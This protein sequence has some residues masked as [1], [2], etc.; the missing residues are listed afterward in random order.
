MRELRLAFSAATPIHNKQGF[1]ALSTTSDL[2]PTKMLLALPNKTWT[3]R[4]LSAPKQTVHCTPISSADVTS[5]YLCLL[6]RFTCM[7]ANVRFNHQQQ[8][9]HLLLVQAARIISLPCT[10]DQSDHIIPVHRSGFLESVV[11]SPNNK[12]CNIR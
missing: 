7:T 6:H 4:S 11:A 2:S 9:S 10:R 3:W 5:T 12:L 8:W 1:L